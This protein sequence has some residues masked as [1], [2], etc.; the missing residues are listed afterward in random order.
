MGTRGCQRGKDQ[1]LE[2]QGLV[3]LLR[4]KGLAQPSALPRGSMT[5][6]VGRKEAK[7]LAERGGKKGPQCLWEMGTALS[8]GSRAAL[9]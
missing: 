9:G 8:Q 2:A 4:E 7:S 5:Q 1:S 3:L 6:H